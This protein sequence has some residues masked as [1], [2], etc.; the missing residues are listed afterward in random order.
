MAAVMRE[1]DGLVPMYL[2]SNGFNVNLINTPLSKMQAVQRCVI[3]N[4][5]QTDHDMHLY[6]YE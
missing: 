3:I 1:I 5:I 4:A 6:T 2:N